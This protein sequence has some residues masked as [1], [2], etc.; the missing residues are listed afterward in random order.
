MVDDGR[1]RISTVSPTL[2][3]QSPGQSSPN[4]ALDDILCVER[5]IYT[6]ATEPAVNSLGLEF[7]QLKV[8]DST[9]A[10]ADA[11]TANPESSK[12]GDAAK[13]ESSEAAGSDHGEEYGE[14]PVEGAGGVAL[15][16]REKKKPYVNP[17]RVNTGGSQ[18]VSSRPGYYGECILMNL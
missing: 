15:P 18:R 17:E 7:D 16:S 13:S 14:V 5:L 1:D 12:A 10:Q 8:A 9:T 3:R 2:T 6:M 4:T 11:T